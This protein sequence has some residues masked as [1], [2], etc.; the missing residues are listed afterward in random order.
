MMELKED[1][2]SVRASVMSWMRES[3]QA[4]FPD[5]LPRLPGEVLN[6]ILGFTNVS[7]PVKFPSSTGG[8][9][10]GSLSSM[11]GSPNI[12]SVISTAR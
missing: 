6:I 12:F 8:K 11:R 3:L 10:T 4:T 7:N 2:K 5:H 9:I 1:I